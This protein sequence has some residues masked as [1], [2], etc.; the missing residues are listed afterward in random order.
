[1]RMAIDGSGE[2]R[3]SAVEQCPGVQDLQIGERRHI[4]F[5]SM[6]VLTAGNRVEY[7]SNA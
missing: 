6:H 4:D 3:L 2:I 7:A 5:P 1:M